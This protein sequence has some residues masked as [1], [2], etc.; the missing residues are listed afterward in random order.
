[1]PR[2]NEHDLDELPQETRDQLEFVLVDSI[3]EVLAN[4]FD[5]D[6][7]VSRRR[8]TALERQAAAQAR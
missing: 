5:G 8:R 6:D 4:A 7:L 3:E 2:E 1:M